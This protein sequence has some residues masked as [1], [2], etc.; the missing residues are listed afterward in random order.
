MTELKVK[1][2]RNSYIFSKEFRPFSKKDI[3][4]TIPASFEARVRRG[5]ERLAVKLAHEALSYDALN[6]AANR[7]A[8]GILA[9]RGTEL[10][11]VALLLDQGVAA[12]A[13]ILG[14]LTAR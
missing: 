2:D 1:S 9:A 7:I 11:P 12:V 10:E 6:A 3:E 13:S 14:A 4:T 5:P 8:H